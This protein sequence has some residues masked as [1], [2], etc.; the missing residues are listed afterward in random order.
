MEAGFKKPWENLSVKERK[1]VLRD[2]KLE[3]DERV[4]EEETRWKDLR[5]KILCSDDVK[6]T[7]YKFKLQG[8]IDRYKIDEVLNEIGDERYKDKIGE[9]QFKVWP[10]ESWSSF[11]L[12]LRWPYHYAGWVDSIMVSSDG[13]VF[14]SFM[15]SAE[16][17]KNNASS[18]ENE[19][20]QI[21]EKIKN[22]LKKE[23]SK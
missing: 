22:K 11:S 8:K 1:K 2:I 21:Y 12:E 9:L 20:K 18:L 7:D 15:R 6:P 16:Y 23:I 17:L 19:A 13:D 14:I 4:K 5:S 10:F 3:A